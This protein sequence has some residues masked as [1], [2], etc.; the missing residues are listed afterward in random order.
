MMIAYFL[1]KTEVM[2]HWTKVHIWF[3][4]LGLQHQCA[5]CPPPLLTPRLFS[6]PGPAHMAG[7]SL[8]LTPNSW[9]G[10]GG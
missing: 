3:L 5:H 6:R 10:G 9:V 1:C 7:S 2:V 8:T 4:S